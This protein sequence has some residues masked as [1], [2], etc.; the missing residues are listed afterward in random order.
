MKRG[1]EPTRQG[2]AGGL[3]VWRSGWQWVRSWRCFPSVGFGAGLLSGGALGAGAGAVAGHVVGGMSR[4]DLK[5]SGDLLDNGT[6][7][8]VVVAATDVEAR[9]EAAMKR[10]KKKANVENPTLRMFHGPLHPRDAERP[11]DGRLL[12]EVAINKESV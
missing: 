3:V 7:G 1:E 6:S 5:E 10:A 4:S 8:L 11:L 12:T 2:A 9:V